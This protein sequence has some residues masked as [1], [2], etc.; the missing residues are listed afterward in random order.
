MSNPNNDRE[1]HAETEHTLETAREKAIE[2]L[3]DKIAED[4]FHDYYWQSVGELII[5]ENELAKCIKDGI[6]KQ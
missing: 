6:K 3:A 1:A 5:T 4:V 2:K